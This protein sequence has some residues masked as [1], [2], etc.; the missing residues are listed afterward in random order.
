MKWILV[1]KMKVESVHTCVRVCA[2]K[3]LFDLQLSIVSDD[4]KKGLIEVAIIKRSGT[5]AQSSLGIVLPLSFRISY[6]ADQL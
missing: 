3:L 6:T 5:Y 4:S 2:C 1:E